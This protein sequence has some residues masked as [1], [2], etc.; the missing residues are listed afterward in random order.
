[1]KQFEEDQVREAKAHAVAGGQALHLHTFNDMGH[2]LFKRYSVI[3]HLFDQNKE[4]LV[5]TARKLGVRV[6]VVEHEGEPG[7]HIDLCGKPLERA[8]AMAATVEAPAQL[9]M[10]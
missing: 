8:K 4:R 10:L 9:A 1:M 7:Q 3:A 6:I 2:P 5:K